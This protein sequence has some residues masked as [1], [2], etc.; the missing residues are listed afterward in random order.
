MFDEEHESQK[1]EQ[2]DHFDRRQQEA[3]QQERISH[4]DTIGGYS[5]VI[6]KM[7]RNGYFDRLV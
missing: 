7:Y 1:S 5:N 4:C 6:N 2:S 3:C